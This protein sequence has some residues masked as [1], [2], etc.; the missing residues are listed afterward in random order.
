MTNAWI[1]TNIEF[2]KITKRLNNQPWKFFLIKS[3]WKKFNI[4]WKSFS[5]NKKKEELKIKLFNGNLPIILEI[6][7]KFLYYNFKKC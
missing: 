5:Y 3:N 2:I 6:E 4:V 7:Q 1:N